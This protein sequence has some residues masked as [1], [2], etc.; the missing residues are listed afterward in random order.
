[1]QY[2]NGPRLKSCPVFHTVLALPQIYNPYFLA[3]AMIRAM[4]EAGSPRETSM[5]RRK[6]KRNRKYIQST[7]T[8]YSLDFTQASSLAVC[9]LLLLEKKNKTKHMS[10]VI[11]SADPSHCLKTKD[12]LVQKQVEF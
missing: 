1:M 5:C 7:T 2:P 9:I 11:C 8:W 10:F 6:K 4:E 12:G 3:L